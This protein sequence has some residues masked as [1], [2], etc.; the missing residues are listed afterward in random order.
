MAKGLRTY[1][2]LLAI[3]LVLG[4]CG[5]G[6]S[7]DPA[8]RVGG[9]VRAPNGE[10]ARSTLADWVHRAAA[11]LVSPA[12]AVVGIEPVGAD[13]EVL[14]AFIDGTGVVFRELATT[15]TTADGTYHF[16]LASNEKPGSFL[17]VSVG[18]GATLM[19]AF[20]YG[21]E[22]DVDSTSEAVFRLV[23]DSGHSLGNFSAAELADIHAAVIEATDDVVAG[24]SV[25]E[26]NGK[27]EQ[28]ASDDPTVI[29][30]ID[31]AGSN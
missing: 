13:T 18:D 25:A 22:I 2:G 5:G 12:R 16:A 15:G 11:A 10:L 8:G 24:A 9:V 19:R 21:E 17:T 4:A 31:T 7:L 23:L 30:L 20:V 14:L 26:T 1:G 3:G 27:V 28:R 29:S 6:G